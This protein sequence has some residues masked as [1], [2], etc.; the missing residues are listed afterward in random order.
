MTPTAMIRVI[1]D[2]R[3]T[4]TTVWLFIRGGFHQVDRE[5]LSVL[6]IDALEPIGFIAPVDLSIAQ[7]HHGKAFR[8][9][10]SGAMP[11]V[12]ADGSAGHVRD[13]SEANDF[14][15]VCVS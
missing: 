5:R 8:D 10:P 11:P 13:S 14:V 15:D 4:P 7:A 3:N 2:G 12:A 1:E 6:R 9:A